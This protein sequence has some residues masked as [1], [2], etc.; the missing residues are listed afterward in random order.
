MTSV[1]SVNR[2]NCAF[3]VDISDL[4]E[5]RETWPAVAIRLERHARKKECARV[6]NATDIEAR[7]DAARERREEILDRRRS[8]LTNVIELALLR[9][10]EQERERRERWMRKIHLRELLAASTRRELARQRTAEIER[11]RERAVTVQQHERMRTEEFRDRARKLDFELNYASMLREKRRVAKID[12]CREEVKKVREHVERRRDMDRKA[13]MSRIALLED[14]LAKAEEA[15]SAMEGERVRKCRNLA[16]KPAPS[17]R[18]ERAGQCVARMTTEAMRSFREELEQKMLEATLRR[19]KALDERAGH[20]KDDLRR[21]TVIRTSGQPRQPIG[22]HSRTAWG[23]KPRYPVTP[24]ITDDDKC[25]PALAFSG[26]LDGSR[27]MSLREKKCPALALAMA[28]SALGLGGCGNGSRDDDHCGEDGLDDDAHLT[29]EACGFSADTQCEPSGYVPPA[30]VLPLASLHH[31]RR[32]THEMTPS[33]VA[34]DSFE[35]ITME[36]LQVDGGEAVANDAKE[37][38]KT[39]VAEQ[40][41]ETVAPAQADGIVDWALKLFYIR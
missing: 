22:V 24:T 37:C 14:E 30:P 3:D 6:V 27:R 7:L 40:A 4:V 41:T 25:A 20:A 38:I 23:S 35:N 36:E 12:R 26:I 29:D 31:G 19:Q 21:V 16:T 13:I 34:I 33:L 8:G 5:Q 10:E 1:R 17:V 2:M 11:H 32:H 28:N 39:D 18:G 15:R 9:S